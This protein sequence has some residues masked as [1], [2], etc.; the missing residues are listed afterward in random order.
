MVELVFKCKTS[1]F[2]APLQ[3]CWQNSSKVLTVFPL[4]PPK[5]STAYCFVHCTSDPGE[6]LA[7]SLS[8]MPW[9]SRLMPL[10]VSGQSPKGCCWLRCS[11]CS[12][13]FGKYFR[14]HA[15]ILNSQIVPQS[16]LLSCLFSFSFFYFSIN[17][18]N[19]S[20]SVWTCFTLNEIP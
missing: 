13:L 6:P 15:W 8:T 4:K 16:I 3:G 9:L 14:R 11:K 7:G 18:S 19:C 17:K 10:S 1:W 12:C 2:S 20:N 5:S